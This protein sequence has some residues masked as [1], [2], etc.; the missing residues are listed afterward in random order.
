MKEDLIDL[1]L[2]I[3]SLA[4]LAFALYH[5]ELP[6]EPEP[7]IINH[8]IDNVVFDTIWLDRYDTLEYYNVDTIYEGGELVIIEDT[9]QVP[10]PITAEHF[11][12]TIYQGDT[13][14]TQIN[15]ILSGFN[16]SLEQLSI[17]TEITP[18]TTYLTPSR[19]SIGMQL[20]YGVTPKGFQPYIGVGVDYRVL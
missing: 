19:W 13:V 2:F 17:H 3:I 5:I 8:Y 1:V 11:D 6:K 16:P 20:G 10:I 12:T 7:V 15:G 18:R 14:R 4:L 9:I